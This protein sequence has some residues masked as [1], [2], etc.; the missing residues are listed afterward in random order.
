M[1]MQYFSDKNNFVVASNQ[2]SGHRSQRNVVN[3]TENRDFSVSAFWPK[4]ET[5]RRSTGVIL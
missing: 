3:S 5:K 4:A 2:I 1:V